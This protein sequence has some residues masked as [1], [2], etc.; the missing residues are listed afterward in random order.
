MRSRK[1]AKKA[2]QALRDLQDSENKA[3]A[4]QLENIDEAV[5]T[6]RDIIKKLVN[7]EST[8]FNATVDTLQ[9]MSDDLNPIRSHMTGWIQDIDDGMEAYIGA[10]EELIKKTM[11]TGGTTSDKLAVLSDW[12][13]CWGPALMGIPAPAANGMCTV[14]QQMDDISGAIDDFEKSFIVRKIV[15]AG[16]DTATPG[17]KI[18]LEKNGDFATLRIRRRRRLFSSACSR[19]LDWSGR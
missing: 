7:I 2:L 5:K 11:V 17:Q 16:L 8:T 6:V 18:N 4:E 14:G 10:N 19:C 13:D 3:L 9:R 1:K 12:H 15:S